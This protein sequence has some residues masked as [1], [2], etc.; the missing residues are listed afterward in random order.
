[1][2]PWRTDLGR[3]APLSDANDS[4]R[5]DISGV[6]VLIVD[7]QTVVRAGIRTLLESVPG[8]SIVDVE[9]SHSAVEVWKRERPDLVIL[10]LNLIDSSGLALVRRLI[11]L[12]STARILVLSMHYESLY[13]DRALRAGARGYVSKYASADE[14]VSAVQQVEGGGYYVERKIAAELAVA[15]CTR[16]VPLNQLT[17]RQFDIFRLL[18]QGRS[19]AQIAELMGGSYHSIAST[20]GVIKRKLSVETMA[21]LIRLSVE[22]R[23][24]KAGTPAIAEPAIA[25]L[26]EKAPDCGRP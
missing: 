24:Y 20:T 5:R 4:F 10:E 2:P 23:Q 3:A 22:S 8:I 13:A 25:G 14:V 11:E 17:A 26:E 12:D 15:N 21:D 9:N 19:Y 7:D 16:K 1:V 6:K 18:G